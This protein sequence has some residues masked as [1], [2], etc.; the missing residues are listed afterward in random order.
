[1][2]EIVIIIAV[3]MAVGRWLKTETK[4][5]SKFIPL[6]IVILAVALNVINAWLFG[7]GFDL[8]EAG[9]LGFISGL[10]AIGIHSGTKNTME[11]KDGK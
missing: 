5:P 6:S 7:D 10:S 2:I 8:L 4:L 11:K 3:V 9:K 1:M